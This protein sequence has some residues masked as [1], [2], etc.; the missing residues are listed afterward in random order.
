MSKG[1]IKTLRFGFKFLLPIKWQQ[2]FYENCRNWYGKRFSVR[3]KRVVGKGMVLVRWLKFY[4]Q[5]N[6]NVLLGTSHCFFLFFLQNFTC[7][8]FLFIG[9]PF[10]FLMH[11]HLYETRLHWSSCL[12]FFKSSQEPRWPTLQKWGNAGVWMGSGSI[13][14]QRLGPALLPATYSTTERCDPLHQSPKASVYYARNSQT[15]VNLKP[16]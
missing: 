16:V 3:V 6:V 12:F 13:F 11:K 15:Q 10:L 2:L 4:L 1:L 9:I 8:F 5:P 14:F 7:F